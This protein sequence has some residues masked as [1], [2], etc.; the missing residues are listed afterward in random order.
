MFHLRFSTGRRLVPLSILIQGFLALPLD[1][2]LGKLHPRIGGVKVLR[3]TPTAIH[4]EALVNITNP[5]PYSASVPYFTAHVMKNRSVIG[6]V[7]VRNA[8]ITTGRVEN[9]LI[10]AV[11]EP[12]LSGERGRKIG[13]DLV[14]EYL[15]GQ[16]ITLTVKAHEK[17]VPAAPVLG[18]VL[19]NFDFEVA[20]PRLNL[21][22]DNPDDSERFIRDATFHLFS[23]TAAFTLVSPFTRNTLLLEWVNATA[24]YNHTE[25]V[26]HIDYDEAFAVPPGASRTPRMPVKWSI[27]SIGYDA[28]RRA[29]GGRLKLD[30]RADVTIR[31]GAFRETIWYVGRGIGAAVRP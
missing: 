22:S 19:F 1:S 13:V 27:G 15:S 11:W 2:A 18:R 6:D 20:A 17:S 7:A 8:R 14:S 4:I 25:P 10:S 29:L 26:G 28:V 16:N 5:T 30:A 24:F 9:L 12:S 23:S 31:I 21:P 3:T